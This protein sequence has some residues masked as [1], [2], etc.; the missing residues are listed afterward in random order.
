MAIHLPSLPRPHSPGVRRRLTVLLAVLVSLPA[1]LLGV[2]APA[3]AATGYKYWNY[4]HVDNGKYA[5]AQT[6]PGDFTP[7]NRAVEAYRYGLSSSASGLPPRTS[8]S[9]YSFGDLCK[10]TKPQAGQKLVGVLIDYGTAA[11]ADGGG[12]PPKPRGA[13]AAVPTKAT[14]QQ[15]LEKVADLRAQGGLVCGIDGYPVKGCS[16]TVKNPPAP[17]T[18]QDVAFAM[19]AKAAP[20]AASPSSTSSSSSSTSDQGGVPWTL[21]VVVLVVVVV[22]AGGLLLARRNK[23][24]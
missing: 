21:V 4:F 18:E 12:T 10:G 14:G 1:V 15:V 11:D 5:F 13:C 6:G 17:A 9:T 20:K 19:P 23:T 8:A 24:A 7:K 2:A 22:A 3:Q 16:V